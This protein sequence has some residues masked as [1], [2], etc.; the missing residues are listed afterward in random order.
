MRTWKTRWSLR[1][2]GQTGWSVQIEETAETANVLGAIESKT[3]TC[4]T[5]EALGRR[6]ILQQLRNQLL[7]NAPTGGAQVALASNSAVNAE[8][9]SDI[10]I[11]RQHDHSAWYD[12]KQLT[13]PQPSGH[14]TTKRP[15]DVP[16]AASLH[17][18]TSNRTMTENINNK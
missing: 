17:L 6:Q 12:T 3:I 2:P 18:R 15:C 4:P 5:A 14:R 13:S 10:D 8:Q 1:K 7:R 9:G 11:F 16:G